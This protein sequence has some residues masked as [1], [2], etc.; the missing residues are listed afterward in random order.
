M[1]V[2]LGVLCGVVVLGLLLFVLLRRKLRRFSRQ[3]FG[4]PDLLQGVKQAQQEA[5]ET[6]RSLSGGDKLYAHRILEDFPEFNIPLA[7][8]YAQRCV[9]DCL[10]AIE[11]GDSGPLC[12]HYG[13][14]ICQ[15]VQGKIDDAKQLGRHAR[16]DGLKFHNTTI[17]RYLD[18]GYDKVVQ[19]QTAYEYR[20]SRGEKVQAKAQLDYT[21]YLQGDGEQQAQQLRCSHCGA[22]VSRVGV[23]VCEYCGSGLVAVLDQ[24]WQFTQIVWC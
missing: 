2:F 16:F 22:P 8:S 7:K 12:E 18:A 20:D 15:V 19:F 4:T 24:V 23:K 3:A 5:Q 9:A 6:P 17:S 21:Y 10:S 13:G 14:S 1:K 11:T